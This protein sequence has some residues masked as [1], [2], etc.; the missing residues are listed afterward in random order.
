LTTN[1]FFGS[2]FMQR[3]SDRRFDCSFGLNYL[4]ILAAVCLLAPQVA[5]SQE[6]ESAVVTN[7]PAETGIVPTKEI[8]GKHSVESEIAVASMVSYGNYRIF[9]AA[10]RC[11]IWTTGVEYSRHSWGHLLKARVDYMVEFLPFVLLSEPAKADFWG[12]PESPNQQLVHGL[13]LSPFGFRF[14]WRG[15]KTIKPYL[16]GKAGVVVFPKKILSPESSYANF[17]FQGDFGMQI[18][19]TDRVDLRVSPVVYFHVSNG[20]LAASNPGFDQLGAKFGVS[21]HLGKEGR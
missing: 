15:N 7:T 6:T 3:Q 19:M 21:Y 13:G 11:N 16:I 17:N 4:A 10:P 2:L 5:L 14:L 1:R 9:G 8:P 18:R 20:Y 12:N